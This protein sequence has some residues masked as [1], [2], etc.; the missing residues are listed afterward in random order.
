MSDLSQT[1][2]RN[3]RSAVESIRGLNP[4]QQELLLRVLSADL[5]DQERAVLLGEG[6]S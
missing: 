1:D 6:E 3:A 2:L 4:N 5:T